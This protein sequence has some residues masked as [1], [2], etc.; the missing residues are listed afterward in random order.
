MAVH[1]ASTTPPIFSPTF[2]ISSYLLNV[3]ANSDAFLGLFANLSAILSTA[4]SISFNSSAVFPVA[5]RYLFVL[6]DSI[7]IPELCLA[8]AD[9]SDE[10][11][12]PVCFAVPAS[13]ISVSDVP[14]CFVLP[15]SPVPVCF[16]F[17]SS[18]VPV[19]FTFP[20]SPVP[21][22]FVPASSPPEDSCAPADLSEDSP[23]F[24]FVPSESLLPVC[25]VP[26]SLV[27]S[28]LP[29]EPCFVSVSPTV[30]PFTVVSFAV[31]SC[32]SV[33]LRNLSSLL[34]KSA[35]CFFS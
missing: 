5:A 31:P 9:L 4:L 35:A 11:P 20:S 21:V 2:I 29:E 27:L 19:C 33:E 23:V 18:P 26:E 24:D 12:L 16:T 13:F 3:F 34:L 15:S 22:C 17:P 7:S 6:S 32:E 30:F 10:V 28:L 14:V 1:I 25:F 8:D